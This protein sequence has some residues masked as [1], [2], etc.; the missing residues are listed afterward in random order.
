MIYQAK[1]DAKSVVLQQLLM[2]A[3]TLANVLVL[4][5]ILLRV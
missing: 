3:Q 4:I 5:V 1:E 2:V